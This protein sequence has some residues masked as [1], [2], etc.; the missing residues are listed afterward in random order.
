MPGGHRNKRQD[1]MQGMSNSKGV[2]RLTRAG[3]LPR[4]TC[5]HFASLDQHSLASL[6]QRSRDNRLVQIP[7]RR[8]AVCDSHT[9][10]KSAPPLHG[11]LVDLIAAVAHPAQ[12]QVQEDPFS[13]QRSGSLTAPDMKESEGTLSDLARKSKTGRGQRGAC[14]LSASPGKG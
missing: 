12:D 4:L 13:R 9:S 3:L 5:V 1:R 7:Q 11:Q 2:A 6:T 10:Y 14:D 8:E